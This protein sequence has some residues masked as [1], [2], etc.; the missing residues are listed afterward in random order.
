M[1]LLKSLLT[2]FNYVVKVM[3]YLKRSL[4]YMLLKIVLP[5]IMSCIT[6]KSDV[7]GG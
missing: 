2:T 1:S 5:P 3:H 7:E 6:K 4:L